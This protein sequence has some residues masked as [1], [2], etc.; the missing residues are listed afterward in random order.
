MNSSSRSLAA[1]PCDDDAAADD[2]GLRTA[3]RDVLMLPAPANV[4]D[5]LAR[6]DEEDAP[7]SSA[8]LAA[9]I[10]DARFAD[11]PPAPPEDDGF[12]AP[13]TL[14]A[15]ANAPSPARPFVPRLLGGVFKA[16][17]A[18]AAL[19][20]CWNALL[21]P[22]PSPTHPAPPANAA[23][24]LDESG[25]AAPRDPDVRSAAAE[26]M[27]G[28]REA[29]ATLPVEMLASAAALGLSP[30][31]SSLDADAPA[32]SDDLSGAAAAL[33]EAPRIES[34]A[35]PEPAFEP[36]EALAPT[37]PAETQ[38]EP[39]PAIQPEPTPAI[40]PDER[41]ASA[42]PVEGMQ[43]VV[44]A[45]PANPA[46]PEEMLAS[47]LPIEP[48]QTGAQPEA[49][50]IVATREMLAPHQPSDLAEAEERA[51]HA[52]VT[53]VA[54]APTELVEASRTEPNPQPVATTPGRI[55][56]ASLGERRAR[57][58]RA[59]ESMAAAEPVP[60]AKARPTATYTGVWA[61]S[62]EACSPE[63]QQEGHLLT[64]ISARRGRAGDTACS[65]RKIKRRGSVWSIGAVCSD[66]DAT[67]ASNIRLSLRYGR[68]TWTSQKGS[69][70]YVRCPRG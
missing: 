43:P 21:A 70:T 32:P 53:A 7:L 14:A 24:E 40:Q 49:E 22:D 50:P 59:R 5:L 26:P 33:V 60:P 61:A 38:P 44:Q 29:E 6:F 25:I 9:I 45:E 52:T 41:L 1:L 65:F 8:S 19:L 16:G 46:Q 37:L 63:M 10:S 27:R 69:T 68:L 66:A 4:D 55:R 35:Q 54:S 12:F 56:R 64:R 57:P 36:A 18:A 42:A 47:A 23:A 3:L 39:A 11:L 2:A 15:N 30:L 48:P 13:V 58:V 62:A 34:Q 20:I 28:A 67:W 51:A 31:E 17:V